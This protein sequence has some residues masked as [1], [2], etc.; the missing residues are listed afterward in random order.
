MPLADAA[1]YPVWLNVGIFLIA[2]VL[3]WGAGTRLTHYLDGIARKTELDEAFVGMLLLGGITSLPEIANT[4]TASAIGNPALA[5]NNLLGSAAINIVLLA[6]ADGWIGRDAVTSVVAKPATLMMA[7]LC[8][9]VLV[10]VAMAIATTDT[11]ILGLGA[12]STA[13]CVMSIGAFWLSAGYD[14]RAPW[15]LKDADPEPEAQDDAGE[16]AS[17]R[18]LVVRSAITGAVIF[19]AGY[20]LSQVGDALAEQTGLGTGIVGFALIGFSTSLPELSSILTALRIG[21]YEMAFGQVL[22]TNFINLSLIL[23]ADAFYAG[24][25][26]INEIGR[27]ETISSL[28]GAVLIGVFLVGL[29]ERRNATVMKM[30]WDSL[31]VIMLFAGG[32]GIL[33]TV[34]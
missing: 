13:L 6:V 24:G 23:L 12:W 2:A 16:D 15:T 26:V 10:A 20:A 25:P 19:A 31:A 21:R 17:L 28:L 5:I 29:L 34:K 7:T 18:S 32:L 1:D 3:V 9:L 11:L 33:Y 4:V 22:G 14:R 8:M 30:G 27:F